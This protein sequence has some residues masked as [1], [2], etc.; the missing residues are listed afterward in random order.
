MGWLAISSSEHKELGRPA[1]SSVQANPLS[2]FVEGPAVQLPVTFPS[3]FFVDKNYR[4]L[5]EICYRLASCKT[6]MSQPLLF[7]END[8]ECVCFCVFLWEGTVQD[9]LVPF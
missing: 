4:Q 7:P 3:H 6:L 8:C 2:W 9:F 1:V 5:L